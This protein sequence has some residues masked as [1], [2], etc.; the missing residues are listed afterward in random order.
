MFAEFRSELHQH[1]GLSSIQD[2][3][4]LL[5]PIKSYTFVYLNYTSVQTFLKSNEKFDLVIQDLVCDYSLTG[6]AHHFDAKLIIF[7]TIVYEGWIKPYANLVYPSS[8]IPQYSSGYSGEM[9]F[10]QRAHNAILSLVTH[11]LLNQL[12][13]AQ[14]EILHMFWPDA[15][16]LLK[17][18]KDRTALVLLNS[19]Y[20]FSVPKPSVPNVVEIGGY[21]IEKPKELPK[22]QIFKFLL[23]TT[24]KSNK[25]Y[26]FKQKYI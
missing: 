10:F 14:N 8:Y 9:T 13:E 21:H 24:F 20:S 4:R 12:F 6:L 3:Y 5:P 15:P 7:S 25:S 23:Q 26:K 17:L 19:H 1:L 18:I 16:D 11:R 22:V 2:L